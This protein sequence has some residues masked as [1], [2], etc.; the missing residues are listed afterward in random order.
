MVY[1]R[2]WIIEVSARSLARAA[3]VA[4]RYSCVRRQFYPLAVV[5]KQKQGAAQSQPGT[6]MT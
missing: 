4:V 5:D 1:L 2:S 3:T 6:L